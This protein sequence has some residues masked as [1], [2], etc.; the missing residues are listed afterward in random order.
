MKPL[1]FILIGVMGF[2]GSTGAQATTS[3]GLAPD[4]RLMVLNLRPG[5]IELN[6]DNFPYQV[7][8]VVM[9]S[10]FGEE[11]FTLS[12]VADGSTSLYFSNG[13]AITGGGEHKSVRRATSY[14]LYGA[15]H[16]Y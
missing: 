15:Q 6:R 3:S 4:P 13:N 1:A 5:D 16:F 14:L 11:F 10:G 9:E 2:A 8:A 7:F 12:S